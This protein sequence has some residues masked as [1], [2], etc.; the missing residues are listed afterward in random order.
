[1]F[2]LGGCDSDALYAH[3]NTSVALVDAEASELEC[4]EDVLKK[5]ITEELFGGSSS[6]LP[7]PEEGENFDEWFEEDR[8]RQNT[9]LVRSATRGYASC[10]ERAA[11]LSDKLSRDL[12]LPDCQA[13]EMINHLKK[14]FYLRDYE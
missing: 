9:A 7:F 1:M 12:Y 6:Y 2:S 11:C 14:E 8:E 5:Q 3:I 4:F 13:L 10:A